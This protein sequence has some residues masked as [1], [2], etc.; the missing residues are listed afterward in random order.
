M[1]HNINRN[2]IYYCSQMNR[3]PGLFK[4]SLMNN[5][6]YNIQKVMEVLFKRKQYF[7]GVPPKWETYKKCFLEKFKECVQRMRFRLR[8]VNFN[9]LLAKHLHLPKDYQIIKKEIQKLRKLKIASVKK[10]ESHQEKLSELYKKLF[11]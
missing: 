11:S 10:D 5:K 1:L 3:Q 8:K 4:G 7:R 9:H 2:S 6:A